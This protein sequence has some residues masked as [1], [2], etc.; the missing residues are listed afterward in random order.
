MSL[1]LTKCHYICLGKNKKNNT[2]NF[3]N[4]SLENSKVEV[5]LGL[6]IDNKLSFDNHVKKFVEKQ[7]KRLVHYQEYQII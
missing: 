6:T 7:V 4:I 2:F 5:I 1:N 3:G